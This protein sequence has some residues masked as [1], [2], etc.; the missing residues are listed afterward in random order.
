MRLYHGY[1]RPLVPVCAF[2][3]IGLSDREFLSTFGCWTIYTRISRYGENFPRARNDS[4]NEWQWSVMVDIP[5]VGSKNFKSIEI[6]W[7]SEF[8]LIGFTLMRTR[9]LNI[10]EIRNFKIIGRI[11]E[12]LLTTDEKSI[13]SII[14]KQFLINLNIWYF[15]YL[16]S[17]KNWYFGWIGSKL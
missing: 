7:L 6:V 1:A 17:V 11:S 14:V 5:F 12:F 15:D 2:R 3:D 13:I 16:S 9:I 8:L 4:C 10:L